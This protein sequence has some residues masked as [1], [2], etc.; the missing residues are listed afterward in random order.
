MDLVITVCDSAASEP[1]PVWPGAPMQAH[2]GIPD[3]AAVTEP[4]EAVHA[5]FE[6]AYERL[7]RRVETFLSLLDEDLP[8]NEFRRVAAI[9]EMED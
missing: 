1:C 3:P 6:Q 2:W 8:R 9:G 7:K 5:A 4:E